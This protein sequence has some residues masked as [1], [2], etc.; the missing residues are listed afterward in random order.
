VLNYIKI[1]LIFAV[2]TLFMSGFFY[3]KWLRSELDL[4]QANQAKLETALVAEKET[5]Q[6]F[7][8]DFE[9]IRQL[10][11]QLN[12]DF[13]AAQKDVNDLRR[14][15]AEQERLMRLA[16]QKPNLVRERLNNAT[17]DAL[18]CNEIVTGAQLLP[19][20]DAN[21]VCPETIK[22]IKRRPRP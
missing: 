17:K 9:K 19:E 21:T 8:K 12:M 5:R 6:R 2:L 22:N 10:N 13:A 16:Q 1:G 20:D 7:E 4:A 18:R 11:T 14:K 3:V 15:F